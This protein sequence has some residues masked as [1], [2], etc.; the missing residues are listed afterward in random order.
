MSRYTRGVRPGGFFT[1]SVSLGFVAL[2]TFSACSTTANINEVYTAL[3]SDGARRRSTFFTDTQEIHCIAEGGFGRQDVTVEGFIHQVVAYD[4]QANKLFGTDRYLGFADIHPQVNRDQ[5]G[6][7]RIDLNL[8]R[9]D[10]NGKESDSAPFVPGSYECQIAL[11]GT[12]VKTARFNVDFPTCP[13]AFIIP[14]GPC[15][16]FFTNK[17]ECPK[18]GLLSDPKLS[19]RCTADKG[20]DCDPDE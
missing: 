5:K 14:N 8:G 17:T 19:C 11:D 18:Y 4:F 1:A 13:P 10:K 7:T 2:T 9:V 16:G 20:W 12:I 3:D 6:P 15:F